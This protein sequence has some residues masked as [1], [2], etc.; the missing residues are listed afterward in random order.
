MNNDSFW[1][2]CDENKQ[3]CHCDWRV[4]IVDCIERQTMLYIYVINAIWSL[5]ICIIGI[6]IYI[7]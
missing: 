7:Y 5:L 6:D 3:N 4:T 1:I 2:V